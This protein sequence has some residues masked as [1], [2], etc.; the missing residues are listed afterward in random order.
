MFKGQ[1]GSRKNLLKPLVS[2]G[3]NCFIVLSFKCFNWFQEI[4]LGMGSRVWK[5]KW[6]MEKTIS[7]VKLI[8][9][10]TFFANQN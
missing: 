7:N 10:S 6:F 3:F 9:L 4:K 1:I 2:S 8:Q 5:F